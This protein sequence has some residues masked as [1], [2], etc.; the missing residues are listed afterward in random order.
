[1]A[2]DS[3]WYMKRKRC[4][5][6]DRK[7]NRKLRRIKLRAKI[8]IQE[9]NFQ[10][11]TCPRVH[12]HFT[13]RM[14]ITYNNTKVLS[15]SNGVQS[16]PE[17]I[18]GL[19]VSVSFSHFHFLFSHGRVQAKVEGFYFVQGHETDPR[20]WRFWL[21]RKASGGKNSRTQAEHLHL[22]QSEYLSLH[23]LYSLNRSSTLI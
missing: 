16:I 21:L 20:G 2:Y 11:R 8:T 5:D 12:T 4:R 1:M 13:R 22:R 17:H 3:V 23:S 15:L 14:G 10:T 9:K 6:T 18:F 7:V 19:P